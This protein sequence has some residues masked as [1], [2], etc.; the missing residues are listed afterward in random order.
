MYVLERLYAVAYGCVMRSHDIQEIAS[1]ALNVYEQ[2]FEDGSPPIHILLRD[3]ARG[4][5]EIAIHL[6]VDLPIEVERIRPP[7]QSEWP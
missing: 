6:G 1:L 4:V 7:Y 3:Y 2:V 5:I